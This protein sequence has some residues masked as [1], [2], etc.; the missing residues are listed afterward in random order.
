VKGH[1]HALLIEA[2]RHLE[3]KR[4][5]GLK[6]RHDQL[7]R[8]SGIGG[9]FEHNELA[10]MDEGRNRLDGTGHVAQVRFMVLVQR[11]GN[12][13]DDRVHLRDFG[14]VCRGV[15]AR[16]LRGLNLRAECARYKSRRD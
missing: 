5:A 10:L 7:F 11:S 3:P 14:V 1:V 9:A 15:E 16:L 2:A 8:G 12:A 4:V 13:D 6:Q